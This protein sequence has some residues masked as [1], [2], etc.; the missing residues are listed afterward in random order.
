MVTGTVSKALRAW[1]A[2]RALALSS[3]KTSQVRSSASGA[4]SVDDDNSRRLA[5]SLQEQEELQ[6]A[7]VAPRPFLK[8]FDTTSRNGELLSL[9]YASNYD[10]TYD[11]DDQT[12]ALGCVSRV[13]RQTSLKADNGKL[14][15]RHEVFKLPKPSTDDDDWAILSPE[16][17][18][19][20]SEHTCISSWTAIAVRVADVQWEEHQ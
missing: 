14:T 18:P 3:V 13:F 2:F 12:D 7:G 4:G 20:Q 19:D 10:Y 15:L 9:E 1:A 6:C 8:E 11:R 16:V 17:T 5:E